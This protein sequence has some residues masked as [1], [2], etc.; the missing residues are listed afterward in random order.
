MK[1]IKIDAETCQICGKVT[2]WDESYGPENFIMCPRCM[3]ITRNKLACSGSD[4]IAMLCALGEI[5]KESER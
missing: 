2:D 5:R 4:V 3:R 1:S